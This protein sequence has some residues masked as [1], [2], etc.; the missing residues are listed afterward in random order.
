LVSLAKSGI[1]YGRIPDYPPMLLMFFPHS[2]VAPFDCSFQAMA[3][4]TPVF[5][6]LW[7]SEKGF[8]SPGGNLFH[9]ARSR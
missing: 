2:L 9:L 4:I 6:R 5:L 8:L 7:D 3:Q 1:W